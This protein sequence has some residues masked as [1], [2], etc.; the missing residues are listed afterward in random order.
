MYCRASGR[1]DGVVGR[2]ARDPS[3]W[4]QRRHFWPD[5]FFDMPRY[6][7]TELESTDYLN[8]DIYFI[9]RGAVFSIDLCSGH[10]LDR[11]S[12]W[13]HIRRLAAW[14]NR[15]IGKRKRTARRKKLLS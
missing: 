13:F 10:Q 15:S 9:W 12:V 1:R 2:K 4:R 7:P 5:R 14:W 6:I 3:H 11:P 8:R